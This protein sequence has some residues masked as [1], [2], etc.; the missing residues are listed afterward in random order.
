M[1]RNVTIC[2]LLLVFL[3]A[4]SACHNSWHG[5]KDRRETGRMI[6]MN[7]GHNFRERGGMSRWHGMTG[8]GMRN[9]MMRGIGPGMG[10]GMMRGMPEDSTGWRPMIPGGRMLESIP[11][12][13]DNQKKQIQDLSKKHFDE[14]RKLREEMS[15]KMQSLMDSHRKD[16]F[17]ILTDEQKKFVESRHG[18]LSPVQEK[19]K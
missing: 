7:I 13:T 14:M 11:N 1:K 8:E 19:V 6:R 10:F 17:N 15:S 3:I 9:R 4:G 12:I 18:N 5:R 16:I 2:G